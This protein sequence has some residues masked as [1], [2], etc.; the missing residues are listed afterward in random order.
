MGNS[1]TAASS[2]TSGFLLE[3]PGFPRAR[4]RWHGM[5]REHF[6]VCGVCGVLS[7]VSKVSVDHSDPKYRGR[8]YMSVEYKP[9]VYL[10][11]ERCRSSI[12]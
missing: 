3:W 4:T 11:I 7:M 9:Y 1:T 6:G 8:L 10:R 5:A 2:D 12:K